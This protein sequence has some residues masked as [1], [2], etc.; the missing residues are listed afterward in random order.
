MY[1]HSSANNESFLQKDRMTKDILREVVMLLKMLN[2]IMLAR[3]R[4]RAKACCP[5]HSA[6][7]SPLYPTYVSLCYVQ[8][9]LKEV[10]N[11]SYLTT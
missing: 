8:Q 5:S 4:V 2:R 10:S 6:I 11:T 7:E 9:K 3:G 1:I